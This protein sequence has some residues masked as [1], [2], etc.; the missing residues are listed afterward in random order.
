MKLTELWR[1][2]WPD[3]ED[4][5]IES[6]IEP[7]LGADEDPFGEPVVMEI[8]DVIDL[9]AIPPKQVK[10]V[11]EEYLLEARARRFAYVRIIHGKGVG[12]QRA[13]IRKILDRTSFIIRYYDAPPGAGGLGATIAELD[14]VER[15]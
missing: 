2:L 10:A 14:L 7:P 12:A 3:K 13:M 4:K 11:V 6:E 8:R 1:G 5:E 15:G 9:H